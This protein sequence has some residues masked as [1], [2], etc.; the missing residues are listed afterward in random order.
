LILG[1]A[2]A[3]RGETPLEL[4]ARGFQ[5]FYNLEYD[6]AISDFAAASRAEPA[7]P[8]YRFRGVG[9]PNAKVNE[10]EI[11]KKRDEAANK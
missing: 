4:V 3:S 5:H 10:A 1:L 8:N 2:T 7:N 9:N 6:E 11:A